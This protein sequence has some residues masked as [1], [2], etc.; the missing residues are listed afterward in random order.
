MNPMNNAVRGIFR[1]RLCTNDRLALPPARWKLRGN[2]LRTFSFLLPFLVSFVSFGQSQ[3]ASPPFVAYSA[4]QAD[5]AV[6]HQGAGYFRFGT[7]VWGPNW[8]WTSVQGKTQTEQGTTT[9]T[10]TTTVSGAPLFLSFR[11]S[12]SAPNRLQLTYELKAEK[13]ADL[14]LFVVEVAPGKVFEGRDVVAES[15]GKQTS[16]RC[17]F[18]KRNIGEQVSALRWTDADGGRTMMQF[19]PPCEIAADGAVRI[20]LAKDHL[21]ANDPRRL[22]VNVELAAATDWFPSMADLPDEPGLATWYPWQGGSGA[23]D[24]A[25]SMADWLEKPAGKHGRILRQGERLVY[26][27]QPIKLWGLNLCYGTCA[28]E[29]A[30]AEK[31]AAFYPRYGINA[32]RL[33]KFADGAGWSGIQSKESAAEYD[34]AGLDR[35]DYQ[36]AKFKEA[37]IYVKLSAHFGAIKMGPADRRDVP[38]LDE[39]GAFSAR[40]DRVSAPHSAL[41]YSPELQN[42]HIRQMVNLLKHRNPHTGLAYAEDRVVC[43]IEIINEQSI[44]FYTSMGPLKQS[45]TLRKQVGARFSDWLKKKYASHEG[46]LKAWGD[47]GLDGFE[48]DG[49]PAGEHL[50]QRNILPLGNPW[51]WDPQQLAGSQ[52][53]RKQRL[54]DTLQ[55]LYELQCDAYDRYVAALRQAGYEGEILGSNWQAGR[56][57]SHYANL[58]SDTRVGLIDRHNYFGGGRGGAGKFNGGSMLARAGSGSLSSGLQQVADRP[59]ML[60]EWIHVFPSEWGAEGPAILGAYALGLQGWD[61]SFMFQNGDNAAFSRQI[62]GQAW[63]VMAPQV[64]GLFP[65]VA[66]Q[67]LR[68][69]V[70]ESDVIAPRRVHAPSL[71]E[72]RLG[73]QD[74]VTQGYDDKELDSSA[75]PAR[76]LAAARC[77]VEFTDRYQETPAFDL[78]QFQK[79]GFIVSSTG[80]LRWKESA[81]TAG[82]YFTMDTDGTKAV[83]GFAQGQVCRLG[84][85]TLTPQ[86]RFSAIYVT[87]PDKD[88]KVASS[89]RLIITAL[90]RA[91]NTGMKFGPGGDELLDKGK[92]PVLM[93]PVKATI[94]VAGR[95]LS[96]V[97]LLDH[98]GRRTE[99]TLSVA[100][101]QFTLDGATD[102]TPYYEL[103]FE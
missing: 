82:G 15:Q 45:A 41:F 101:G 59:F 17:P 96:Q 22:T 27:G 1:F 70:R 85:L 20:V 28:P 31:R 9:G 74:Q 54:L 8:S 19:D 102:K 65:A 16:L 47:K 51:Y 18:G 77:T 43:A 72:G 78:K 55:F 68:G 57:Y 90:A 61:V 91:R 67:V 58:H 37:G 46:L 95:K 35:M 7:A 5:V 83:V 100:N 36:V 3:P 26:H 29:K 34:P 81:S 103:T 52:A 10:L 80:Q 49:F 97:W 2:S 75:V 6:L 73:F 14:T 4:G 50:D 44:F 25:L 56:A 71:F 69:D 24:S 86:S 12:K 33:H 76:A 23:D 63:D 89:R 88:G 64:L 38:F 21:K 93:E 40:Q 60:S 53:Y 62:G 32:V 98:D 92:G 79:D 66:R 94:A 99:K 84:E 13:D 87:A 39:F 30:L 48:K 42:L 11:V